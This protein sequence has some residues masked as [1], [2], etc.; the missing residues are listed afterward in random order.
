MAR[1]ILDTLL[2]ED[3][4]EPVIERETILREM[5]NLITEELSV[6]DRLNDEV[7]QVLKAHETEIERGRLDYRR[8]FDLTKHKMVKERGIVL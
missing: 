5:E 8:L 2:Q 4:I 1:R 6:E 3:L 7:R